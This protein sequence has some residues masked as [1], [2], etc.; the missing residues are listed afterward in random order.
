MTR[1]NVY[2][3][4]KAHPWDHV[5]DPAAYE[6][7]LAHDR[8]SWWKLLKA[9]DGDMDMVA[10]GRPGGEE[11]WDLLSEC[12]A[13]HPVKPV[14]AVL[15]DL[16]A[17]PVTRA[18]RCGAS[19]CIAGSELARELEPAIQRGLA[20]THS[21][22]RYAQSLDNA[23]HQ[24]QIEQLHL[25]LSDELNKIFTLQDE[26]QTTGQMML[27]VL[28]NALEIADPYVRGHSQRVASLAKKIATRM[29]QAYLMARGI[30]D[31][32][33]LEKAGLLHDIGKL[34][35]PDSVLNK[36]RRLSDDDWRLIKRHPMLGSEIV[37]NIGHLAAIAP[38]IKHH[39]ERW[40]GRGY[41]VGLAGDGIPIKARILSLADSFDAMVSPRV[42]REA[43]DVQDAVLDVRRNSGKQFDPAVVEG[44]LWLVGENEVQ[45]LSA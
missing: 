19:D 33:E 9:D 20:K 40:D 5:L 12:A 26:L 44:L 25:A 29:N 36:R 13:C 4:A 1:I 7:R 22:H 38:D 2:D 23:R 8:E 42:Y 31:L 14:I 16:A 6:V 34:G 3:P 41:P 15:P 37:T 45:A 39:H 28:V 24:T 11:N 30:F 32:D 35:I 43:K 10:I 27:Q 18:V 21:I 17:A